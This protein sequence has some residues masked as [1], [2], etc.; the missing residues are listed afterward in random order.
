MISPE[1]FTVDDIVSGV[2]SG[3]FAYSRWNDSEW[4]AV[5]GVSRPPDV[6]GMRFSP[7]LTTAISEV[8]EDRPDYPLG[9][10]WL[11]QQVHEGG[12]ERW[13][14]ERG[15]SLRWVTL[16]PLMTAAAERTLGRVVEAAWRMSGTC[17]GAG[18]PHLAPVFRHLGWKHV[19]VPT[20]RGRDAFRE[21]Q[22]LDEVVGLAVRS[23]W[24]PFVGVCAGVAANLAVH[25]LWRALERNVVAVD[26]G[27]ALDPYAGVRSRT[28]M[29]GIEYNLSDLKRP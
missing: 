21:Q 7:A 22:W 26:F 12:A 24:T 27:S 4:M 14:A 9:L 19:A 18:P 13:L 6:N 3:S 15:L 1:L 8:L 5:L 11:G 20:G 28:Y 10:G 17:I 29:D 16:T 2:A 23:K 25:R